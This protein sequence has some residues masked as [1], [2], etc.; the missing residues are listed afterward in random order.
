MV[1]AGLFVATSLL[2]D[3]R[4]TWNLA[5]QFAATETQY[6]GLD[7]RGKYLA[8]EDGPLYAF[9]EKTRKVLPESP[10]RLF[11]FAD[12]HYFR[13]R[14]AYH[15]Y[16]NNVYFNPVLNTVPLPGAL[17]AGDWVVVFQ[18]RGI[19]YNAAEQR[20]RWDGGPTV[21][22]ELKL[23]DPLGAVFLIK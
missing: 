23:V 10:V 17:H 2:L 12:A 16:P 18:R 6:A 4:W 22:A 3:G 8:S 9:V 7:S 11:V 13:D 19:Q 15:L 21:A 14:A 20:L 5:R 1:L